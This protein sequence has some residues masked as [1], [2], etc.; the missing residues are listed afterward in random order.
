MAEK[1][2]EEKVLKELLTGRSKP[3]ALLL[4][5]FENNKFSEEEVKC[6][7]NT[8]DVALACMPKEMRA[9]WIDVVST[10]DNDRAF[11]E[12]PG[13]I[14]V[15]LRVHGSIDDE[16]MLDIAT[17]FNML[18]PPTH[19]PDLGKRKDSLGRIMLSFQKHCNY[20]PYILEKLWVDLFELRV[21]ED[22]VMY[23]IDGRDISRASET[24]ILDCL[25][26]K[27]FGKIRKT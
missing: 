23:R 13:I 26:V 27:S 1:N 3:P 18:R 21:N 11:S 19:A 16:E 4:W 8:Y 12:L 20:I 7:A 22:P 14:E 10:I 17:K 25:N 15:M 2:L 6:L 5:A 9:Q 24:G